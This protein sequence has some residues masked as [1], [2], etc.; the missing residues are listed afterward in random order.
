MATGPSVQAQIIPS[1]GSAGSLWEVYLVLLM[2]Q[3]GS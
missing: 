2:D 1:C 3:K